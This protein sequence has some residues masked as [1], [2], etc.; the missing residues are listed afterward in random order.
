MLVLLKD[1]VKPYFVVAGEVVRPGRVDL[2]GNVG[3]IEAIA[4]SG[5]FKDSAHRTQVI[6]LRKV[7]AEQ[8]QISIVDVRKL[9]TPQGVREDVQLRSGDMLVVP[10]NAM[11]KIAPYMR[12]TESGLYGLA[13]R[14]L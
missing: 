1:Y 4:L 14:M 11:S 8:A 10:R 13:L 9:M 6:F 5:G 12:L 7:C 2:H 3:L